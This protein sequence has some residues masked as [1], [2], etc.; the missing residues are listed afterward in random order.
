MEWTQEH[1]D[2]IRHLF[3]KQRGTVEIDY[4]PFFQALHYIDKNGCPWRD[5]PKEFGNWNTMAKWFYYNGRWTV[6]DYHVRSLLTT[7]SPTS[8]SQGKLA[9][10]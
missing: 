3:P 5:L 2:S 6:R 4:L 1:I 8:S 7:I 10:T 9:K